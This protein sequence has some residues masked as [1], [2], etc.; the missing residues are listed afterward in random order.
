MTQPVS[1]EMPRPEHPR[2]QFYRSDWVNLNG[3]W[4]FTFDFGGTGMQR[5]FEKSTGFEKTI[6][7]PFCPESSLSGIGHTDFIRDIWYQRP[8]EINPKWETRRIILHLGAVDYD[9][10]VFI[11]GQ[12]VGRHWGGT[13]SF[14]F[15]ITRYVTPGKTHSLVVH[16]HDDTRSGVQP[17]GKQSEKYHS[18][19]CMYTRT[20]G[21]WQTVWLEAAGQEG[22]Q[23]VYTVPDLDGSRFII[24]P[25]FYAVKQGL[26]FRATL[27]DGKQVVAQASAPAVNGSPL[28]LQVSQPQTLVARVAFPL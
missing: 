21:I 8:L 12:S 10:E 7:V 27:R 14:S 18:Y 20:T 3:P 16:A 22:L 23:S 6:I 24:T 15:D 13:V 9:S 25:T 28:I 2:P 19:G 17:G 11:D 5:G 1:K 26:S 4:T